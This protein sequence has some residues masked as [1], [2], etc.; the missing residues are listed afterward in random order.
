[1]PRIAQYCSARKS[2]KDSSRW[3]RRLKRRAID[4]FHERVR[5]E[6]RLICDVIFSTPH[7]F[8]DARYTLAPSTFPFA[9]LT[10]CETVRNNEP[11]MRRRIILYGLFFSFLHLV[12]C[13]LVFT[14]WEQGGNPFADI[15]RFPI[16]WIFSKQLFAMRDALPQP[17]GDNYYSF[18]IPMYAGAIV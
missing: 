7:W 13:A 11:V 1:M 14:I 8:K 10:E 6:Y 16:W 17:M 2:K 9:W 18:R 15:L 3:R 12:C 5:P 4:L